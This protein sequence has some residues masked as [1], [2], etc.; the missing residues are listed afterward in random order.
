MGKALVLPQTNFYDNRLGTVTFAD[1]PCT[2]LTLD[3]STATVGTT[4]TLLATPTPSNTTDAVTWTSSDTTVATVNN[5][6][7][8]AVSN[9]TATITATCG[10]YSA[11]CSVTVNIPVKAYKNGMFQAMYN[12]DTLVD[13]MTLSNKTSDLYV[14]F[15][16][17]N[18]K[19]P[20]DGKNDDPSGAKEIYPYPIPTGAKTITVARAD[21]GAL[22]VYYDKDAQ[23]T[24]TASGFTQPYAKVIT[25]ETA[26]S[27]KPT[28]IPSWTYDS[29]TFTIPNTEGIDSFTIGLKA[30]DSTAYSNFDAS[31]PGITVTFGYE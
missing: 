29:R 22:I 18:G 11:A 19:Y 12:G 20:V 21:F 31:N 26:S 10:G 2:G 4:E 16:A 27:G 8:T 15:G 7:V 14:A 23:S 24:F 25:G 3:K 30:K 9:G 28:S 6:V 5:G 17:A 13:Y 1:I